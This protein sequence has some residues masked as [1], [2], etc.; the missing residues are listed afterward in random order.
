MVQTIQ[1]LHWEVYVSFGVAG[2]AWK[3]RIKSGFRCYLSLT[4]NYMQ[5]LLRY[6]LILST[7][8]EEQ[9][10]LQSYW[11]TTFRSINC[12]HELL[13]KCTF[14]RTLQQHYFCFTLLSA[15]L[16]NNTIIPETPKIPFLGHFDPF[17]YFKQKKPKMAHIGLQ[18]AVS[19]KTNMPIL[20][21][22]T[23]GRTDGQTQI[24]ISL[25]GGENSTEWVEIS[26]NQI[27]TKFL[28]N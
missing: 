6:W 15:K 1:R 10:I 14:C 22:R 19:E 21:K 17:F 4:T 24:H 9:R 7:D 18:R 25:V 26:Y 12:G 16:Y 27:G 2:H 13:E 20:T 3:H 5:R 11:A 28:P 8:N 23:D